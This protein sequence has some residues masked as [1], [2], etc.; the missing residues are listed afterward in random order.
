MRP[1]QNICRDACGGVG[2]TERR[3]SISWLTAHYAGMAGRSQCPA[4]FHGLSPSDRE[5]VTKKKPRTC[6]DRHR[7]LKFSILPVRRG[8]SAPV[9]AHLRMCNRSL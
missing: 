4:G 3:S 2:S 8:W 9:G 5:S 7:V 1:D 6:A